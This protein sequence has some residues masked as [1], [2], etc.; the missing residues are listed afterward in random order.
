MVLYV[1]FCEVIT[2]HVSFLSIGS[3]DK[4]NGWSTDKI[5]MKMARDRPRDIAV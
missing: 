1:V 3:R 4:Y 5:Q 2:L